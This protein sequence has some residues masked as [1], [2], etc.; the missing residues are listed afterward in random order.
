MADVKDAADKAL[1]QAAQDKLN[2]TISIVVAISATFLSVANVKDGNIVQAMARAQAE[3]IDQWGYYQAKSTKQHVAEGV[4]AQ[5]Q[6]LEGLAPEGS[7]VREAISTQLASWKTES[8]RYE[9]QKKD[10]EGKARAALA[11]YDALNFRDDQF[12]MS[13][14]SLSLAIALMGITALTRQRWLLALGGLFAAFGVWMGVC[15]F[16]GLPFHPNT[17][18]E[19]LS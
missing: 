12:D 15:G 11:Q 10:I 16:A 17:F 9:A 7:A 18:A 5:L 14:A 4:L 13:E 8:D 2:R 3:S 19:W 6:A 1:E